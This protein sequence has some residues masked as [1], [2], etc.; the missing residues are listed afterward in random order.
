MK[1][2]IN[3]VIISFAMILLMFFISDCAAL[4]QYK[5]NP[6]SKG[7]YQDSRECEYW[8]KNFPNEYKCYLKRQE[9]AN[10]K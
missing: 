10:R 1:R 2:I 8:K 7:E 6:C 4:H 5:I 3:K 9:K